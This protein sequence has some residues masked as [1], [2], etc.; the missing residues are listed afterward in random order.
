MSEYD[1]EDDDQ[2]C[3]QQHRAY[4]H[5][6]TRVVTWQTHTQTYSGFVAKHAGTIS[7]ISQ[8]L[9][10]PKIFFGQTDFT[11]NRTCLRFCFFSFQF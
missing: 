11:D 7:H 5:Q 3:Q 4:D 1:H 6:T 2:Q 8:V 9:A 10:S